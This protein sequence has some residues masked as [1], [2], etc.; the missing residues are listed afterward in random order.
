VDPIIAELAARQHGVVTRVQLLDAGVRRHAV[1]HRIKRGRLHNEFRGVFAVGHKNLTADGGRMATVLAAGL[2]AVVSHRAGGALYGLLFSSV[3][4]ITLDRRH[5]QL[6]GL[7]VHGL[8]LPRDEVTSERGIPVTTV[9]RTLFDL[10]SVLPRSQV[11]RAINEAEVRRL[12]D[13]LS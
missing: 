8:P 4:E 13:P 7:R 11:E 10:A 2:G 12:D 1:D 3:A 9:P 6:R 5:R